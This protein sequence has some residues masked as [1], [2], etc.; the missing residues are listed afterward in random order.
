MATNDLYQ[1]TFMPIF[2]RAETKIKTLILAAFL[3]G[4]AL[5]PLRLKIDGVIAWAVSQV[6]KDLHDKT[7]YL[8]G[9]KHKSE[10]FILAYY[11]KPLVAYKVAKNDLLVSVPPSMGAPKVDNPQ[12]LLDLVSDKRKLWS[13]AKG[14]P[15]VVNYQKEIKKAIENLAENPV[16]T[17]EPG[18]KPISLWQ[19]AELDVRHE[20]QVQM[21]Q[22][23]RVKGVK[24]AWTSSHPNCSKR[25][26][27]WQGK[28]MSLDEHAKGSNFQVTT[29]DGHPVFSLP[30]IMNQVDKYGYHNNI[31]SG[32]NCRHRLIPYKPGVYGPEQYTD[33][34]VSKERAIEQRIREM[35]REIR[36]LK[37][38]ALLLSQAG[39]IKLAH[40]IENRVKI[41]IVRYK[42][43]CERNGYAWY[44]YRINI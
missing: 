44:Q 27:K 35:E 9:L 42:E 34:D 13:A 32:F 15:N 18:K 33:K 25:C 43:Y 38:Q 1:S 10:Q 37:T 5:I 31:I 11:K 8:R 6:P 3:S 16:T 41:L 22:D 12:A 19:K 4:D 36:K 14:S 2:Q 30:D 21:L 24:Y 29:I 26:Q 17:F 39:Q 28:L 40:E 23:L 20:N 7:A